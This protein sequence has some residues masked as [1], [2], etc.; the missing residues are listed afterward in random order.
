MQA[1]RAP[2]KVRPARAL[3]ASAKDP[4]DSFSDS[5]SQGGSGGKGATATSP[6]PVVSPC[7]CCHTCM[8]LQVPRQQSGL[9]HA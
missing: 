4:A 8:V 6:G 1:E 7:A 9:V 5:E 3:P 2:A